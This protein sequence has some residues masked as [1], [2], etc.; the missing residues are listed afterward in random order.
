[1]SR[2]FIFG[3]YFQLVFEIKRENIFV[4][5]EYVE[6]ADRAK[7]GKR[8]KNLKKWLSLHISATETLKQ[9][10]VCFFFTCLCRRMRFFGLG[11]SVQAKSRSINLVIIVVY[12]VQIKNVSV[13]KNILHFLTRF[14]AFLKENE[15]SR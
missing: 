4:Q 5:S 14:S 2:Y 3:R 13:T 12:F 15:G 6:I 9:K 8:T 10:F 11:I 7:I 1:M